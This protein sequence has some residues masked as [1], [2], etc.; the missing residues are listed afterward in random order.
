MDVIFCVVWTNSS[1]VWEEFCRW[2]PLT[3]A[4]ENVL[5]VSFFCR[6]ISKVHNFIVA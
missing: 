5:H 4:N 2:L 1:S 3:L 6:K